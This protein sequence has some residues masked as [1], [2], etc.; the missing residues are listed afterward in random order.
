MLLGFMRPCRTPEDPP[1]CLPP[2]SLD[3]AVAWWS[4][5]TAMQAAPSCTWRRQVTRKRVSQPRY[6]DPLAGRGGLDNGPM[7]VVD[8]TRPRTK[9]SKPGDLE[10]YV[11][12]AIEDLEKKRAAP[13][14]HTALRLLGQVP[15]T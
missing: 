15:V 1:G 14:G 5:D 3:Q 12:K 13:V 11:Q 4:A 8:D 6:P 7:G 2:E 9:Q 10:P